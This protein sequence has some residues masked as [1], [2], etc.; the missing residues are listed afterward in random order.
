MSVLQ[1]R[2]QR[3]PRKKKTTVPTATR[4]K[5]KKGVWSELAGG[6]P[7][8][9][10]ADRSAIWIPVVWTELVRTRLRGLLDPHLD[11]LPVVPLTGFFPLFSK[12]EL[13]CLCKL[14]IF[15][16]E[17]RLTPRTNRE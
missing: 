5:K 1:E 6:A 11:Q 9:R 2:C 14:F 17:E 7:V 3:I 13:A 15:R 8:P 4:T 16:P 10:A 12:S